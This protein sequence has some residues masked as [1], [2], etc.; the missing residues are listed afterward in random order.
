MGAGGLVACVVACV[1]VEGVVMVA[2]LGLRA[3]ML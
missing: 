2:V 1:M 3:R